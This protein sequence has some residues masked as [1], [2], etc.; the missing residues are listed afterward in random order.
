MEE[1]ETINIPM[2]SPTEFRVWFIHQKMVITIII[3]PANI[4]PNCWITFSFRSISKKSV[5]LIQPIFLS[6]I[7]IFYIFRLTVFV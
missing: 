5:I 6:P 4:N 7:Y 3:S 2:L 1:E